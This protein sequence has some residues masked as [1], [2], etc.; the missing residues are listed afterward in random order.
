V[1]TLV[2]WSASM[3]E[4]PPQRKTIRTGLG[5][6]LL[7]LGLPGLHS[8]LFPGPRD[9]RANNTGELTGM[10]AVDMGFVGGGVYLIVMGI[11]RQH[12]ADKSE[13]SDGT[14]G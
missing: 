3:S 13:R 10:L 14:E 8:T 11:R 1:G 9:Q 2:C 4:A 7:V 12:A 6:L 5:V